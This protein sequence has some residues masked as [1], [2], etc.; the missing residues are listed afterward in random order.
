MGISRAVL[1]LSSMML[2]VVNSKS[3]HDNV[4][5]CICKK[6]YWTI[7]SSAFRSELSQ[8]QQWEWC[9]SILKTIKMLNWS[10]LASPHSP[11]SPSHHHQLQIWLLYGNITEWRVASGADDSDILF[12]SPGLETITWSWGERWLQPI[13]SWKQQVHLCATE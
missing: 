6:R 10:Q 2:L 13:A 1:I 11:L 4:L 7:T 3:L 8:N 5:V 12:N 9:A